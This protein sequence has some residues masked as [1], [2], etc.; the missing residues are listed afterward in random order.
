MLDIVRH[1]IVT[2]F[3]HGEGLGGPVETDCPAGTDADGQFFAFTSCIGDI[4]HLWSVDEIGE[5]QPDLG[6]STSL[7]AE[8][9]HIGVTRTNGVTRAQVAPRG[10]GTMNGKSSIVRMVGATWEELLYV[11][12]DMLHIGFPSVRNTAKKKEEPEAVE[13]MSKLFRD[14][15]EYGRLKQESADAG[16]P[17]PAFDPRLESLVPFARAARRVAAIAQEMLVAAAGP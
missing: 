14:A 16:V 5:D 6:T 3:Q 7:N 17:G 9:A 15:A 1:D 12:E 4:Q 2:V 8:S 13:R 11:D 10:S